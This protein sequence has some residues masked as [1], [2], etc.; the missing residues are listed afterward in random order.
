MTKFNNDNLL[1][2]GQQKIL[3]LM[4]NGFALTYLMQCFLYTACSNKII[5]LKVEK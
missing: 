5:L 4:I 1:V 3:A 2:G